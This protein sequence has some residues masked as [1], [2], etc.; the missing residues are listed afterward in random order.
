M[1]NIDFKTTQG[2]KHTILINSEE[3]IG[4]LLVKYFIK[5]GQAELISSNLNSNKICFIY[6]A[7]PLKL[8]DNTK[9]KDFF[10]DNKNPIIIVNDVNN[11]IGA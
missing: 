2:V 4:T 6:K 7:T 5:I 11:L 9:I 10:L 8:N 3:S 1:I